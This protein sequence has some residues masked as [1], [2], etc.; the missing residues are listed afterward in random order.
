M[1]F[2]E[3]LSSE[4]VNMSEAEFNVKMG[5]INNKTDADLLI[6]EVDQEQE[7]KEKL[8]VLKVRMNFLV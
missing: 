7:S 5:Y 2:V 3:N 8:H 6:E 4:N 1:S